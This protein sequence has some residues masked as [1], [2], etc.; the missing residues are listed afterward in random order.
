MDPN[1]VLEAASTNPLMN[2]AQTKTGQNLGY[3]TTDAIADALEKTNATNRNTSAFMRV[4]ENLF[5][6]PKATSQIAKTILSPVTHL[7]NFISAGAFAAANGIIPAVDTAAVKS[8]YQ[9]LQTPLKGTRI[10]NEFYEKLL[11]L[12]VVNSNV[13]LGDLTRLL[14]DV[15]FGETMTSDRGMR[16]LLKPLSKLKQASQDLYTAEDD[17]WKIYSWSQEKKRI[18]DSLIK[19]GT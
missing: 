12:G 1:K 5:L 18:G 3:F 8:A 9:A 2:A 16:L 10:Q 7:R 14:E 4:Y 17:F 15:R 13:R 11:R 19:A 6:Y